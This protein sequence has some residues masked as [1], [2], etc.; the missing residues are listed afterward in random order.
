MEKPNP[1]DDRQQRSL[2]LRNAQQQYSL[3]PDFCAIPAHWTV[4]FGPTA[5]AECVD[6]LERHWQDIRP[7]SS[8][9]A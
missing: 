7:V 2:V 4:A 8:P 1:F 5:H 9:M 6:W 3:W